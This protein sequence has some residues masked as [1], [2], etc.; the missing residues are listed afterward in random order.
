[1]LSNDMVGLDWSTFFDVKN[2]KEKQNLLEKIRRDSEI[3]NNSQDVD[4]KIILREICIKGVDVHNEIGFQAIRRVFLRLL[5][6]DTS[7]AQDVLSDDDFQKAQQLLNR[8]QYNGKLL[9]EVLQKWWGAVRYGED[10]VGKKLSAYIYLDILR[11]LKA[12]KEETV[13]KSFGELKPILEKIVSGV[14]AECYLDAE[15]GFWLPYSN[16]FDE[17]SNVYLT[18][19]Y[20]YDFNAIHERIDSLFLYEKAGEAIEN[21]FKSLLFSDVKFWEQHKRFS[22]C[23]FVKSIR[24][25]NGD[26]HANKLLKYLFDELKKN[27]VG[28]ILVENSLPLVC[29]YVERLQEE[30]EIRTFRFA[31]ER[32]GKVYAGEKLC[33]PFS[34]V[35][36]FDE[37]VAHGKKLF[38]ESFYKEIYSE[39]QTEVRAFLESETVNPQ[40]ILEKQKWT[41]LDV[42]DSHTFGFHDTVDRE[43]VGLLCKNYFTV[44]NVFNRL[45]LKCWYITQIIPKNE[46]SNC[47]FEMLYDFTQAVEKRTGIKTAYQLNETLRENTFQ[48]LK[49]KMLTFGLNISERYKTDYVVAMLDRKVATWEESERFPML[50]QLGDSIYNMAVA[51]LL[52]FNPQ[53]DVY[54]FKYYETFQDYIKASAQVKIVKQFALDQFYLSSAKNSC[55]YDSD[56]LIAPDRESFAL[57]QERESFSNEEKYLADSLE[58]LIGVICKDCGLIVALQFAKDLIKKTYAGVFTCEIRETDEKE[59]LKAVQKL[60]PEDGDENIV[61]DYLTK[62]L[63]ALYGGKDESHRMLEMALNKLL[64]TYVLGTAEKETRNYI[65]HSFGDRTICED[66]SDFGSISKIFHGYLYSGLEFVIEK[67][68]AKIIEKYKKQNNQ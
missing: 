15:E 19:N 32:F 48:A 3:Y 30:M 24:K 37:K 53:Y 26:T 57:E 62:I 36:S 45:Y 4:E 68:Q 9:K 63:P 42:L 18:A 35:S 64:L 12:L 39:N 25:N 14:K 47:I 61:R 28:K 34:T 51:E 10:S 33:Y 5:V 56:R 31:F 23:G 44:E 21:Q 40:P 6:F 60:R 29:L 13:I 66:L 27:S 43:M 20:N 59:L 52:F 8:K 54:N 2:Q 58:M 7:F 16:K 1:M 50:E 67:Y 38:E 65:T 41:I 22:I 49:G 11:E 46:W 17:Q 55:K